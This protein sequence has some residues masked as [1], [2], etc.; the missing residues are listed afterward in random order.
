MSLR[1]FVIAVAALLGAAETHAASYRFE[2]PQRIVA[3]AD[4]HGAYEELVRLLRAA[5]VIDEEGK[6]SGGR[7]HLVSLGDIVDRGPDSRAVLDLL[8]TLEQQAP[9]AGGRVHVVLGNHEMMNL[10]GDLRYVAPGEFAAFAAED[11][12]PR[13]RA[14]QR[15][16]AGF[17][18]E[19]E[20]QLAF[21]D[22]FPPGYFAHR[23]AFSSTGRYGSWL[24]E[25]PLLIV[26]GHTAFAHGGLPAQVAALGLE[27]I[28]ERL[29]A[30][31]REYVTLFETLREAGR[32]GAGEAAHDAAS[33]LRQQ[34]ESATP[35]DWDAATNDQVRR[36]VEL[37]A[38]DVFDD[39]GPLW[40]RGSA[41]CPV[42]LEKSNLGASLERIGATRVVLGH[43]PT[44]A[45]RVT[46]RHDGRVVLAD[47]G[48]SKAHYNGTPAAVVIENGS[49]RVVYAEYPE[50][51]QPVD[52]PDANAAGWVG[53]VAALEAF[54]VNA[55]IVAEEKIEDRVLLTLRDG[56]I[57]TRAWKVPRGQ[58]ANE[59][60]AYRLDRLL[61]LGLVPV[62]VERP[63]RRRP[64]VLQWRA[65]QWI[66]ERE[67]A[68]SNKPVASWCSDGN[69]F[70]LLYAFDALTGNQGRNAANMLYGEGMSKL[71][72][73]DFSMAFGTDTKP[74]GY[75]R[76][77]TDA[78]VLAP[79][80]AE[81]FV[82]LEAATLGRELEG[83]L[84]RR[85]IDALLERRDEI[86][87]GWRR[88]GAGT[89]PSMATEE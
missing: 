12:A 89:R 58:A 36:F 18:N 16:R 48:M 69:V 44:A 75:L 45:R 21:E 74:P 19:L 85:E 32:I 2:A 25:R 77:R 52:A 79:A 15:F 23:E 47:T 78:L 42:V 17:D 63:A 14:W 7:T 53:G 43:T 38:S 28:N 80:M 39:D 71:W 3:F 1:A 24:L 35:P 41:L 83:W 56:V 82:A 87:A 9:S 37:A 57:E 13:A 10:I 22:A 65:P 76:N 5:A 4:V 73:S 50:L 64:D 29:R 59:L 84:N 40:Y 46:V 86:V 8:M 34:L 81:R 88:T 60:A 54:L 30:E 62:T 49:L 6:W 61:G 72:I 70:D 27:G 68:L 31:L 66:D 51:Q 11:E 55:E 26:I 33:A 20:A 67:R